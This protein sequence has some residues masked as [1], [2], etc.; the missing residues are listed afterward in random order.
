MTASS[1]GMNK[2]RV[3]Y[4]EHILQYTSVPLIMAS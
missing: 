4:G 2:L 1:K 3:V